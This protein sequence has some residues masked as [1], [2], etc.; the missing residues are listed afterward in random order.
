VDSPTAPGTVIAYDSVAAPGKGRRVD[1]LTGNWI[2]SSC[3]TSYLTRL[4]ELP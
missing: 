1:C 4:K 3:Q 2:F